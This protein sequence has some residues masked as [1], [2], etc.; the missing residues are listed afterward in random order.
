M[1]IAQVAPLYESVPPKLYGGTE[2]VVY[3]LTEELIDQGHEVTLFASGDSLTRA[4]LESMCPKALRSDPQCVDPLAAQVRMVNRIFNLRDEFDVVHFHIDYIH[5]PVLQRE[6]L[7][8]VTTLHGR[9]DI[10]DLAP[11]YREFCDTPVVSIS[12]SQREPLP[13]L[14]WRRTV[15]HGMNEND[16][17][18]YGQAGK[19]LAFL[20]RISPEKGLDQAIR[21]ARRAG[22]KLKVAAKVDRADRLYFETEIKHLLNDPLVE[23]I[24]E[25]GF[26]ETNAFLG[27]A[28]ALLFPIQWPEPFGLVMIEAMAAGTP[29]IAYKRGSVP[30]VIQDGV[31]G[32]VVH[33]VEE[34]AHAV[35][36]IDSLD[37]LACRKDFELRFSATR[38]C[39]DYLSVYEGLLQTTPAIVRTSP[40]DM[41]WQRSA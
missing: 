30:E 8:A 41:S 16:Y 35:T 4:R 17:R 33:N 9:L 24:G 27:N 12:D 7:P 28:A 29:V 13:W 22:M 39:R 11:L 21:I 20:G 38:M 6:R 3:N 1:R 5:F 10:P 14:D 25:I 18:F 34:A 36:K 19:Y 15:H 26:P 2:R 40:G 31:S 32:F 37:R 23:F